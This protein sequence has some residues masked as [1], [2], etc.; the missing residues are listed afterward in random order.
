MHVVYSNACLFNIRSDI[1][2]PVYSITQI[3]FVNIKY[4]NFEL[5]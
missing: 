4:N 3:S 1:F 5:L 2:S